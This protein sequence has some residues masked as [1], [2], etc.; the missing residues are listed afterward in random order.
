MLAKSLFKLSAS[1]NN[2]MFSK[3]TALGLG[4]YATKNFN[5]GFLNFN[6]NYAECA[7][8]TPEEKKNLLTINFSLYRA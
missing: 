3:V 2:K 5:N 7:M 8:A 6:R 1:N 4:L